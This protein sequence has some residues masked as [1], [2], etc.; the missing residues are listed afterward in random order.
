MQE[1][2]DDA[3]L[4]DYSL[5]TYRPETRHGTGP[6]LASAEAVFAA[7]SRAALRRMN[8]DRQAATAASMIAI[9]YGFTGEG[10]SWLAAKIP[11]RTGP[12]L[13]PAQLTLAR[14]PFR[15]EE[16]AAALAAYQSSAERSGLD[17]D[18]VLA[19]LLHLHHARMIGVDTASERHCLRL[20]RAIAHSAHAR[21]SP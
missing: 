8:G 6:T 4:H 11:H 1:L 18:V 13:N 3:V 21:Q 17:T 9:A 2:D 12:R 7:D 5:H 10:L 14:I 16:L 20:V 19:D 15:D